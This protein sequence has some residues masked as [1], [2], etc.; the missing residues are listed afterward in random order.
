MVSPGMQHIEL[1]NPISADMSIMRGSLWPG[2]LSTLKYNLARQQDRVR[3]FESGLQFIKSDMEIQQQPV[4]AGLV[5]G[6]LHPE[7]WAETSRKVD[8]Y[9]VKG[10]VEN[11]LALAGNLQDFSFIAVEDAAL[12]PGQAA[13]VMYGDTEVGRLGLLHPAVQAKL[14][15]PGN[16]YV[17]ELQL[18]GLAQVGE[19]PAFRPL[20]K[21]PAIRRDLA[22]LLDKNLTFAAVEACIRRVAPEIVQDIRIFDVYTGGNIDSNVKSLAL[23]LILQ[24]SSHTLTDKEV[25][26]ATQV[27]LKAL[28]SEL[29][30]SLRD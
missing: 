26:S 13:A 5:N 28:E 15:L 7:Q 23:S 2:L 21:F 17:F 29:S 3:L 18:Q 8:F 25:E 27:I 22:L 4:L 12:H 10:D 6:T 9:D 20:S 16:V 1:A 14:D 30:A 19:L 11:I 24:D